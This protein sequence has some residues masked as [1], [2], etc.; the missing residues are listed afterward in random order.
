MQ[1]KKEREREAYWCLQGDPVDSKAQ[2]SSPFSQLSALPITCFK[3]TSL[4]V[5]SNAP[6]SGVPNLQAVDPYLLSDQRRHRI[7]NKAHNKSNVP[8]SSRG[9]PP[10]PVC[11]KNHETSPWS[12]KGWELLP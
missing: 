9:Q 1:K 12:Q 11:G 6:I 7:R 2:T 4:P 3:E 8:E 10:T 5:S